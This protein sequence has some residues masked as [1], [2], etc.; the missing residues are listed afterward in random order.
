MYW[1]NTNNKIVTN[2]VALVVLGEVMM[3]GIAFSEHCYAF[4]E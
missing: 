1:S 4:P 2:N 3:T